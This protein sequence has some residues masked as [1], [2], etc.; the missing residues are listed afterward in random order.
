MPKDAAFWQFLYLIF[1]KMYDERRNNG[2]RQFWAFPDEPF[3]AAGRKKIRER[4][5]PL[6]EAVKKEYK[7]IFRGKEEITLSDRAL[8]Y[9]VSELARY[10]LT[11]TEVDVKGAA[12]QEIVESERNYDARVL[13]ASFCEGGS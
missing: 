9:M 2:K 13:R 8:G 11:R 5:L 7:H 4:I 3:E 6:F 12:Y 10:D 1:A